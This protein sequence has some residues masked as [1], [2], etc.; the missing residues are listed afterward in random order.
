M[1]L[2]ITIGSTDEINIIFLI[3]ENLTIF[4]TKSIAGAN[5][6]TAIVCQ[7]RSNVDAVWRSPRSDT[8]WSLWTL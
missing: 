2:V 6:G 7:L 8:L 5:V 1:E 4:K 3:L